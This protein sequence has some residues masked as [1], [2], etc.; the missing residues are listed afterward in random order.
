MPQVIRQSGYDQK[1]DIWSVGITAIELAKGEPPLAEISPM[2][3]LFLIPKARAPTLDGNFSSSFKDFVAL[4]LTKD[5]VERPS[6]KD[7][8]QHRFIKYARSTKTLQDVVERYQEWRRRGP[9]R[10]RGPRVLPSDKEDT[11]FGT[12]MSEWSFETARSSA[13]SSPSSPSSITAVDGRPV[14]VPVEQRPKPPD[15]DLAALVAEEEER[16]DAADVL[17]ER[18]A[19]PSHGRKNSWQQRH[20]INGTVMKDGDVGSGCVCPSDIVHP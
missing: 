17:P 8:L 4:C 20:D 6:A 16:A 18:P 10:D 9:V 7:L 14:A 15:A 5:P 12:L 3:V 2:R 1:A 13:S 11:V 19:M